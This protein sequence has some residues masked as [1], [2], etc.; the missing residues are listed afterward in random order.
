[1][2]KNFMRSICWVLVGCLL[3][4]ATAGCYGRFAL[5]RT[6]YRINGSIG[7]K[8]VNSICTWIFLILPVYEVCGLVDFLLLNV[9]QFWTGS[10]PVAMGP[11]DRDTQLVFQDNHMYEITATQ[12]RFDVTEFN[13]FGQNKT[14][15]LIYDPEIKTWYAESPDAGKVRMAQIDPAV[16][17]PVR[18]FKPNGEIIEL[19]L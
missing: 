15:S 17:G 1:M 16:D 19:E 9:I 14:A 5:T 12:N 11:A 6:I 18:F 8:W 4:L 2:K 10:N 3:S 13:D 7:D